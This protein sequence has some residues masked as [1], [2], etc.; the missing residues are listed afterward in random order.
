MASFPLHAGSVANNVGDTSELRL[1]LRGGSCVRREVNGVDGVSS[2]FPRGLGFPGGACWG[3]GREEYKS[4]LS[5][6]RVDCRRLKRAP[7]VCTPPGPRGSS[8]PLTEEGPSSKFNPLSPPWF[9]L[10]CRTKGKGG[11]REKGRRVSIETRKLVFRRDSTL[12]HLC[13]KFPLRD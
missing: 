5:P 13:S 1:C 10:W 2:P 8:A 4:L 7:S 3:G 6:S 9:F 11:G 12:C